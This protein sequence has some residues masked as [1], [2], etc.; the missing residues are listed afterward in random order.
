[1]RRLRRKRILGSRGFFLGEQ[2]RESE[3]AK[4]VRATAEHFS[5]RHFTTRIDSMFHHCRY[6]NSA[7]FSRTCATSDHT[8]WSGRCDCEET[9]AFKL[10]ISVPV[11]GRANAALYI[12]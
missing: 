3:S 9:N 8:S 4:A 10:A 12:C 2:R 1:M 5:A 6:I 7:E 11:A